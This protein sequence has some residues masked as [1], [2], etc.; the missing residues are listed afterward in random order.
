MNFKSHLTGNVKFNDESLILR[1]QEEPPL[2][3]VIISFIL[4]APMYKHT[5]FYI[6]VLSCKLPCV[7]S[8]YIFC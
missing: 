6:V 4:P 1:D 3:I 5:L 7:R 2:G 8:F